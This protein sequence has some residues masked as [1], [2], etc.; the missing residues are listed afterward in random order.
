MERRQLEGRSV[1]VGSWPPQD[2]RPTLLFIHGAGQSALFWRAQLDA[3]ADRANTVAIDLPGHGA[4]EEPPFESI[5]EQAAALSAWLR[6]AS[7]PDP[8]PVG[9]SMGGAITQRVLLDDPG[10]F[11]AAALV[12]TGARLRV[13]RFILEA[14][15]SDYS[16]YVGSIEAAAVSPSCKL[17]LSEHIA[18]IGAQKPST[19]EADFFACNAFDVRE[20]IGRVDVPTLVLGGSDDMLTPPKIVRELAG[21]L[22]TSRFVELEKTGHFTPAERPDEVNR[23]ILVLLG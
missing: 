15:R 5:E 23:E 7:L 19:A 8:V 12:S 16:T 9:F 2:D 20:E 13:A 14:I 21:L 4:S 11:R 10:L 6:S 1:L 18:D 3:L 22:P 17:D